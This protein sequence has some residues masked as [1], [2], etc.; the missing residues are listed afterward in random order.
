M[1]KNIDFNGSVRL[2]A[3]CLSISSSKRESHEIKWEVLSSGYIILVSH[4]L[5]KLAWGNNVS[6]YLESCFIVIG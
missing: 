2:S 3:K 1:G 5:A 4:A 6:M